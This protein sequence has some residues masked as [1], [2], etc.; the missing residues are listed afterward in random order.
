MTTQLHDAYSIP[1][2]AI[3]VSDP[4]L[5][6]DDTWYPYFGRLRREAPVHWCRESRYGPYWSVCKYKDI[7]QVEVDHQTYSSDGAISVLDPPKGL[8]RQ[9]FIAMDPPKHDEQRKVVSPAVAPGNLANMEG[10][11]RERT[12]RVLEGLPRNETFDWVDRVSIELTT[13]MLATLFDYPWDD[14]RQLTYWSDV[15]ICNVD[16]PDSPVHSEEEKF[17][18]LT[19][20][21]EAL[22]KLFNERA[23]QPPKFDLL[24]MLAHAQATQDMPFR[25]FMG[26]LTLLIVGGND[27]T[28]NSMTGGLW[29]LSQ[30]PH[31]YQK[32]RDD[33]ALIASLVPEIIRYVTPVIHMRRTA[34]QDAELGGQHIRAGDKV[35]MWYVSGNRDPD[36]I[37][38]PD[39]F[40]ID[41]PRPRQHLSFGFG[42]HR[43]VGNRLAELQLRILWEELLPRHPVIEVLRPPRRTYSNFIH[44]MRSMPVRIPVH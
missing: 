36:A 43:C 39:N 27:T 40:I 26:N 11:I 3:D 25:E 9:S 10:L 2:E 30:H 42:I 35:V 6:Q 12:I 29:T 15:A 28:R 5:Y 18:E 4:Q 22:G 38:D 31:E 24:S 1:L 14:R 20:M 41:R 44:G 16:A 21:T 17:A 19:K 33:P 13:M 23:G 8:E 37:E 34:A 32:L 7:M